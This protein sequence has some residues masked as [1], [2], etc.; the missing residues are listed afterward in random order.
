MMRKIKNM[1]WSF[2]DRIGIG[3]YVSL[4][5]DSALKK[6]GWLRS[7]REKQSVDEDGNP[8]PWY[9]YPFTKFIR[10]R[11]R[12]DF[13]V[14]EYGSGNS[15]FWYAGLISSIT[16][17]EH[18]REWFE[19][20][21]PKLPRNAKIIYRERGAGYIR[22]VGEE[23]T[24]YQMIIVDG[25]DRVKSALYAVEYL[26]DDGVLILDNSERDW[27]RMAKDYLRQKGFRS[28]DFSG[29]V[30]IVP[31]ESTTSVFYRE[32]NCLGI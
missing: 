22:A 30:P 21:K 23:D 14:F 2:L 1:I 28:I 4:H 29:M 5:M 27:Y 10:T 16:A 7:Y 31:I 12:P 6:Y 26:T 8:V 19:F 13:T 17:V 15:T 11:L 24:R 18:E 9:T 3:G 25:R 20:M 32:N